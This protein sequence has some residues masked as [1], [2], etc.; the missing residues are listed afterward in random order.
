M[1]WRSAA[2]AALLAAAVINACGPP[3]PVT[4]EGWPGGAA[5]EVAALLR[6][7]FAAVQALTD[8]TAE[9]RLTITHEQGRHSLGTSIL[10]RPPDLLRLDVQGPLFHHV[11]SAV[12]EADTLLAVIEGRRMAL[13]ADDGLDYFLDIDLGGYDPRW[14]LLGVVVP[15]DPDTSQ[16]RHPGPGRAVVP[17]ETPDL[18]PR[19]L[20]LDLHRGFVVGEEILDDS[21]QVRWS[22]RLQ[23][24][25][26]LPGTDLYLPRSVRI[27]NRGRTLELEYGKVRTGRGLERAAF[28]T[29]LR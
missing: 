18:P 8:L 16:V 28:F 23:R 4:R 12:V 22:R 9:A 20:T 3:P 1:N 17:L 14:A 27:E 5:G 13:H 11:L 24:F 7:D 29:G 26:R 19:R 6:A 15:G 2:A 10:F 21:G 25:R